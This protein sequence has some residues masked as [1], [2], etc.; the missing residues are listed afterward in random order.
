MHQ[1]SASA[2]RIRNGSGIEFQDEG[3]VRCRIERRADDDPFTLGNWAD[4]MRRLHLGIVPAEVES[5]VALT[6]ELTMAQQ[7]AGF[8]G[9]DP[10]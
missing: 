8:L 10:H 9:I 1:E 6:D 2:K 3:S 4:V 5:G 7:R